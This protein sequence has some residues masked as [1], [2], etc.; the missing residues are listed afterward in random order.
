MMDI[1]K[2]REDFPILSRTVYNRPL[3]YLDN[4]A[5]TQKPR[6]VVQAMVDEY[7]SV[8]AN[9]HRGVH[10]LSQQATELHE[11]ARETVRRFINARSINEIIFTRGTTESI[12][13]MAYSFGEAFL[14]EG[15]EVIIS[16]MEHHSNIVP[17][18]LLA[19]RKGIVIKVIPMTDEGELLMDAI[20]RG[21]TDIL[22]GIGGSATNDGGMG[23][24]T[25]LGWRFLDHNGEELA[26]V[27]GNLDKI[28]QIVDSAV[29]E[30]VKKLHI[31]VACDVQT[32]FCGPDGA[33]RVFAPQKG[34]DEETVEVLENGMQHFADM[35][36]KRFHLPDF[37][38]IAGGGA[39]G[40]LGGAL[41][42]FL[43]AELL[44]GAEVVLDALQMDAHL[45]GA[46]LVITGEGKIDRQTLT[47]K[48]PYAVLQHAKRQGVPT[49]VIA[50]A[51][52]D[53]ER[54]KEAGFM[55]IRNINKGNTIPPSEWMQP[56]VARK[57]IQRTIELFIKHE[58]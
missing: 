34:A 53:A 51:V 16:T 43:G 23:M 32:P 52:E 8:N 45:R 57:Q 31:R 1:N 25:A 13:L 26:G 29:D 55:A 5:T 15:D 4:G 11:A 40:G 21:C 56:E 47:G 30:A 12:N 36:T 19:Q 28:A 41:M 39:A 27:G 10:F 35:I 58:G 20:N 49:L 54:L 9:V 6:C 7:Y 37:S 3:V 22:L 33:T 44:P 38:T 18:Q 2:I 24:L 48:V 50:G 42:A 17:W 46:D 14:H